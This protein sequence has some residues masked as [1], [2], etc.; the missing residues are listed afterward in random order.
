MATVVVQMFAFRLF[1]NIYIFFV[2][3]LWFEGT[4]VLQPVY[5]STLH[6][7][8]S[9][10]K[11]ILFILHKVVMH[12]LVVWAAFERNTYNG[13]A[14]TLTLDDVRNYQLVEP[15]CT[16]CATIYIMNA[17]LCYAVYLK[18]SKFVV[19]CGVVST[20][21]IYQIN[22]EHV[23]LFF[24]RCYTIGIVYFTLLLLNAL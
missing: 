20:T 12:L 2:K 5:S 15:W 8:S 9:T 3:V 10:Y 22:S 18:F 24:S 7:T 14:L 1:S 11:R 23:H 21:K 6:V 16:I 13:M 4:E 19:M 17:I